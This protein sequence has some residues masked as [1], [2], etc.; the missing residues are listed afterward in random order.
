MTIIEKID[1][2]IEE[3]RRDPP[4]Q[5]NRSAIAHLQLATSFIHQ[6][7]Q[8]KLQERTWKPSSSTH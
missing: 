2:L 3:L 4:C 6:R 7:E 8:R 1:D 5:E